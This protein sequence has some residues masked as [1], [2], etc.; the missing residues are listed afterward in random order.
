MLDLKTIV[1][2]IRIP[3]KNSNESVNEERNELETWRQLPSFLRPSLRAIAKNYDTLT[4]ERGPLI[5]IT[6]GHH[7]KKV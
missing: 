7:C 6:P 1:E 5:T 2:L 3:S 4:T